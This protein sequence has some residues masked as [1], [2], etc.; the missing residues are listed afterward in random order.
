MRIGLERVPVP[1][2]GRHGRFYAMA[3]FAVLISLQVNLFAQ[4]QNQHFRIPV[5]GD[6]QL[7]ILS[8]TVLELVRIN[9]KPS[10][11][12]P[13]ESWDW[14]DTNGV[15]VPPDISKIRVLINGEPE[16]VIGIGFRRRPAYAPLE[17]RDLRLGN[18]LYL[19]LDKPVSPGQSVQ[20]LN[21]GS[22]WPTNMSFASTA[23]PLRFNPAIHVNQEGYL[24]SLPKKAIVGYYLGNLGELP[25][26]STAFQIVSKAT[27]QSV[28]QGTLTRRKDVGYTY[29]PEPYQSVYEADFS[30]LTEPGEYLLSVTG[31]GSSMPFRI[32]EG[33]AMNLARTFAL[34]IFH[35]RSGFHVAMPFTR[36]TH[37]ADHTA[38]VL[39]PVDLSAPYKFT[40]DTVASYATKTN[41]DNPPQ[42]APRLV[43]PSTQLYP[44]VK[45]GSVDVTGGHFEAANYSKVAWNNAQTIHILT[46][47][48]DAFPG[49]VGLDNMGLPE[50]GDNIS[51]VLQEAKWEADALSKLQDS[52]GG[53]YYMIH[54]RDR[55]YEYDVL[56]E[57]GDQQVAWPKNTAT[58]A[59]SV[60]ALVQLATS[61][62][63][64]K[65]YPQTSTDYWMKAQLGWA[66]L[67]NAIG[68][69]GL[70]GAYQR[71]MHFDDAFTHTDDLAWAACELFLATGDT[72]YRDL[73]E[74]WL[75]DPTSPAT[76]RWGWWGMYACY[77]NAI[78]SYAAAATT[79]RLQ[80][81]QINADYLAKCHRAI[82]N[83]ADANLRWSRENAYGFSLSDSTK[84]VLDAGWFYSSEQAFEIA[85]AHS[86]R[87]DPAYMDA[88]LRNLNY[89]LGCNP[90][91]VSYV[92]GLGWKRQ[93][94]VVDQY[95]ANDHRRLPKI[96][97]PISNIQAG[98]VNT[99]T[100]GW[101]PYSLTFPSD[102]AETAPYPFYDRWADFWNVT[103]EASTINTARG[104]AAALYLTAGT[105]AATLPWRATRA[106]IAPSAGTVAP[107]QLVT[108][109]LQVEEP[110][111]TG[112]RITW[113]AQDREPVL[114]SLN[115]TLTAPMQPGSLW[116]E[117]EI[118]WPDGR[119]AFAANTLAVQG[120]I[121]TGPPKLM[122]PRVSATGEFSFLLAGTPQATYQIQGSTDM[123]G[124]EPVITHTLPDSGALRVTAPAGAPAAARYFRVLQLP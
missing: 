46:Y 68:K 28:H 7:N 18:Y 84:R 80:P 2:S 118:H 63:F 65:A 22:L 83:W 17:Q 95:S 92:T 51:D 50:S 31:M 12:L 55:E 89:E 27:G 69:H 43:S 52:D 103:T 117:A 78:R 120:A 114:G 56:P 77:G 9:I 74:A 40:W 44:F 60:A 41:S 15:F 115:H 119:R 39:I 116:V 1:P 16:V 86:L 112:A 67:T 38:P 49:V 8:P 90:V 76:M 54:P 70:D 110:D 48:A 88:I 21:D 29:T 33:F 106:V 102:G 113:E 66:F 5:P 97:V 62:S 34:G 53:F 81:A 47:A 73:L 26:P 3:L 93:R 109:S 87:P 91:N 100:Y 96:G 98:F 71:L 59:S 6:Y 124:W 37:G 45:T 19:R 61:P 75:P 11:P 14:V 20:V 10:D 105:S 58:T 121:V 107:G 82:T 72:K 64:K 123:Q 30:A 79:G 4:D 111:I 99:W 85:V 36:F 13:V 94:N 57:N 25:I 42:I 23:D 104:Y 108:L 122:D 101:E 32:D 35:Q 24:P